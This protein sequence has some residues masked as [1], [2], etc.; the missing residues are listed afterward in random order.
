MMNLESAATIVQSVIMN[1]SAF[2]EPK[3][4]DAGELTGEGDVTTGNVTEVGLINYLV[5][6]GADA[7]A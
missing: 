6:A 7:K 2:I 1:C 3:R 5:N 4:N